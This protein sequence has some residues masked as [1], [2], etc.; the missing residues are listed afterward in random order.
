MFKSCWHSRRDELYGEKWSERTRVVKKEEVEAE[1]TLA[2]FNDSACFIQRHWLPPRHRQTTIVLGH[3]Y[4]PPSHTVT[5]IHRTTTWSHVS[6]LVLGRGR[7]S[8]LVL[9]MTQKIHAA[10]HLP[11]CSCL[12]L[13]LLLTLE[14]V[15]LVIMLGRL[16]IPYVFLTVSSSIFIFYVYNCLLH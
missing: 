7:R 4:P 14:F 16:K 11:S 9:P 13:S 6:T 3:T 8:E 1:T 2:S 5:P 15:D 10:E 12:T